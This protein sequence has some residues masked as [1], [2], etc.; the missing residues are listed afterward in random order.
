[1][2]VGLYAVVRFRKLGLQG[3]GERG[4]TI[5]QDLALLSPEGSAQ[6]R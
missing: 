1:M 3:T 6:V 2:E 5:R 4:L